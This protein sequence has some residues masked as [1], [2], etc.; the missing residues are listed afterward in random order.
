MSG[1]SS[2]EKESRTIRV[3]YMSRVEGEASLVIRLKDNQVRDI[4]LKIFEPPRLFE[5]LLKG[6]HFSEVPDITARICGICP[7]AYQMTSVHAIERAL[8]ITVDPMVRLLRRLL[9][10]G[11]W[12]ESHALHVYLLHIPDFLGYPDAIE[13]ARADRAEIENALRIKKIGNAIMALLGGREIHPVS[14]TV[15]GFYKVPTKAELQTLV[16]ELK[17]GLDRAVANT[18]RIGQF[19][20]PDFEEDYEFVAL[21]HPSEYP[22]NEGRL[23]S[24]KGLDIDVS[25]YEET[26]AEQQVKHSNA[27]HS[28]IKERG[29]YQVGALARVNLN[30]A[31]LPDVAKQ[32]A[33]SAGLHV[34]CRNPFKSII[35]RAVEMVFALEEARRIISVYDPPASPRV[36]IPVHSATGCAITEAPRGTLYNRYGFDENGILHNALIVPPTS[37]NQRRIEEDLWKFLPPFTSLR[38]SELTKRCEQL[39]RS[40][41]PCISCATHFLRVNVERE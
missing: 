18:H 2:P 34:P 1:A 5:A 33:E 38:V 39:V 22:F 26:F 10:A 27:L 9:Y 28:Q 19:E 21:S 11:E 37:Q 15:G 13:M 32:A 40:Y 25:E 8:G 30:Y 24:S 41:D 12:L 17:W 35:A 36:A 16:E 29:S 31:K 23:V 6:R 14:V 7:V 20:F 4:K 3:N